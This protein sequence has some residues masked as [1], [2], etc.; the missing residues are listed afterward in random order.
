MFG[1]LFIYDDA[2]SDGTST[3]IEELPL[4]RALGDRYTVIR[5]RIGNSTSQIMETLERTDSPYILKI[6]NDTLIPEGTFDAAVELMSSNAKLGFL[7]I[8]YHLAPPGRKGL[9]F[10]EKNVSVEPAKHIGGIGVFRRAVFD[11]IG[12]IKSRNRFFGFT[13]YQLEAKSRGW[14]IGWAKGIWVTDLDESS[15]FSQ[16]D[17]YT[18]NGWGRN[19]IG[20]VNSSFQ[21]KKMD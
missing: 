18:Q 21:P 5:K 16:L 10:I 2:S 17:K 11:Q 14:Q 7:G 15:S 19:I 12:G 4:K 13:K 1:H 6:D 9:P 8:G 3:F 20:E